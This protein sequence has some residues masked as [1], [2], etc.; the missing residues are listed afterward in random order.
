MSF[1]TIGCS[2][3]FCL[4]THKSYFARLYNHYRKN[5]GQVKTLK[6]AWNPKTYD[7][8]KEHACTIYRESDSTTIQI[9]AEQCELTPNSA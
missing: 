3:K 5:V 1:E 4:K 6:C 7:Y 8:H 9:A 2:L